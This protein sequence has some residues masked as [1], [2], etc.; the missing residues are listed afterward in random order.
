MK[1]SIFT[2]VIAIY[3]VASAAFMRQ[4][5]LLV[6]GQVGRPVMALALWALFAIICGGFI[7]AAIKTRNLARIITLLFVIGI[8][9]GYAYQMPIA[10]ERLHLV[11]YGL[12]SFLCCR[13]LV[14]NLIGALWGASAF[15]AYKARIS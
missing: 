11:Q 9:L 10:E 5:Q 7:Y 6:T 1:L 4:V 15:I 12:L 14:I 3:I 8:G 2:W 13:D